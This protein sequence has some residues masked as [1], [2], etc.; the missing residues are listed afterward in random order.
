M[1]RYLNFEFN[2][3]I[4]ISYAFKLKQL[5]LYFNHAMNMHE[6]LYITSTM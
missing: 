1:Y 3:M 6:S 2:F 5:K 4:V